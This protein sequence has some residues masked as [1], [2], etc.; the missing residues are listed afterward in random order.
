YGADMHPEVFRPVAD[1]ERT[2]L[3][4]TRHNGS[5]FRRACVLPYLL[6]NY[7]TAKP[8]WGRCQ[9]DAEA[10]LL[11]VANERPLIGE[12]APVAILKF[13]QDP[14]A[15][16][17]DASRLLKQLRKFYFRKPHGQGVVRN[18]VSK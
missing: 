9:I 13:V 18:R 8:L 1:Q 6:P 2:P 16:L 7:W 11:S 5:G 3:P 10:V 12:A 17:A 14:P 4:A 15:G